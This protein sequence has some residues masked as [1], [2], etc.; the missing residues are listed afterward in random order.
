MR[1]QNGDGGIS[2]LSGNRRRPYVARVT[3]GFT[4][5]RSTDI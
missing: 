5:E 4:D 3:A 1:N 2:K